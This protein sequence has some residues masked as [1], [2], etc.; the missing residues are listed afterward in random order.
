MPPKTF[1][2]PLVAPQ[3][4]TQVKVAAPPLANRNKEVTTKHRGIAERIKVRGEYL[5]DNIPQKG[6]ENA[7]SSELK[8][9]AA[10]AECMDIPES[11]RYGTSWKPQV[12]DVRIIR[13]SAAIISH[14]VLERIA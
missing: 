7:L 10:A 3:M 13:N 6:L 14:R 1:N 12:P 5:S 8:L 4:A 11:V 2:P 9:Q